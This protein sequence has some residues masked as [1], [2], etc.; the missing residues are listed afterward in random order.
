MDEGHPER[1]V[2]PVE[3]IEPP[4]RKRRTHCRLGHELTAAN[5]YVRP[6][7]TRECRIC[8]RGMRPAYERVANPRT[9]GRRPHVP[10][11]ELRTVVKNLMG[12]GLTHA[13]ICTA[14]GVRSTTTL[15]VHYKDD[16]AMGQIA[17]HAAIGLTYVHRCL[18]GVPGDP[19]NPPD[20]RKADT[21]ALV[22][23]VKSRLGWV[24]PEKTVTFK[25]GDGRGDF[26]DI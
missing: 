23:F 13:Q 15:E 17:V 26:R 7:G 24:E 1:A 16:L 12:M 3:L 19:D 21:V 11:P 10:T 25:F 6:D 4:R 14:I 9:G 2:E 20:W 5:V 8:R 18:G 22:H